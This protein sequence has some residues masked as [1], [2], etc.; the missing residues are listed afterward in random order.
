MKTVH[1]TSAAIAGVVLLTGGVAAQKIRINGAGAT[2]P[3]PIYSKWFAEYN[4]LHPDVAINYQPIGSGGGVRQLINRTVFFGSSD[5]PMTDEQLKAAP[6]RI[7]H[8]PTILGAVVPIYHLQ[9][10]ENLKLT[11][12]VLADIY[13]GKITKWNDAAIAKLNPGIALPATDLAIVHRSDGSGTTYI[14]LDYLAKVSS[15]FKT[16]VGVNSSVSWPVGVGGKGNEGVASLVAQTPGALGYVELIYALQN[17]IDFASVQNV[18]GEFVKASA[19]SVTKAAVAG[20]VPA[21]FRLSI[22][23]APGAGAYPIA[24][25]TWLLLY[26]QTSD[27]AQ[28]KAMVDFLKWAISDGQK[29]ATELGYAPLPPDVVMHELSVLETINFS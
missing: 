21:D 26:Q 9:G 12:G 22:T 25:F 24:S 19:E 5:M 13:L 2:F 18:A 11:G 17:K 6:A 8:L 20:T 1:K 3:T 23:N 4:R 7:L 15:E 28:G 16:R 29:F 10:V 27:A 14:F